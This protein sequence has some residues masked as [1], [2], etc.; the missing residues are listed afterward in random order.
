[1]TGLAR[2]RQWNATAAVEL[3]ELRGAT[4][5][6]LRLVAFEDDVVGT[7]GAP[8]EVCERIAAVLDDLV[9]RPYDAVAVR[10]DETRWMAGARRVNAELVRLPGVQA[11][12]VEVALAPGGELSAA[13]DGRPVEGLVAPAIDV[14]L[15][16]LEQRGRARFQAFAARADNLDGERWRLT[17]DPL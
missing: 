4:A 13:L 17:I 16:E 10:T 6:E 3:P 15:R 7:E 2:P 9:Q 14:A 1:V 12:L 5:S 8:A 11:E